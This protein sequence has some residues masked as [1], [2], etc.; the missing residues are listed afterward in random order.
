MKYTGR[1]VVDEHTKGQRDR[2]CA[3]SAQAEI[4]RTFFVGDFLAFGA[5]AAFLGLAAAGFFALG[6]AGFLALEGEL[7]G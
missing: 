6:A 4:E 3:E 5:A 2:T 1:A 7:G